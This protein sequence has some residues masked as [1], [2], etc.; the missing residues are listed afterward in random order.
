VDGCKSIPESAQKNDDQHIM[1]VFL[2]GGDLIVKEAKY[3]KLCWRANLKSSVN[4]PPKVDQ[5]SVMR[6]HCE[7]YKMIVTFVHR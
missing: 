6:L 4:Y 5:T 2:N 1:S 3:H 7:T